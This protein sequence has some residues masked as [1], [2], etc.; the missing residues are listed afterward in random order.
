MIAAELD[1]DVDVA[2]DTLRRFARSNQLKLHEVA[3]DVVSRT[4][5]LSILGAAS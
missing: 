5:P 3:A 2:L 4:L 1:V